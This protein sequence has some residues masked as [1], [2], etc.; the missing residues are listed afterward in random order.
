[1]YWRIH[2]AV[3]L[4]QPV[5]FDLALRASRIVLHDVAEAG[6]GAVASAQVL[7]SVTVA[8]LFALRR[9]GTP[10]D[11]EAMFNH[12]RAELRATNTLCW[13]STEQCGHA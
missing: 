9:D 10:I 1:M 4:P 12:I 13:T 8:V 5:A 3:I 7:E 11:H 6:G 2:G